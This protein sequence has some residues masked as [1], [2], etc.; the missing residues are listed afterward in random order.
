M[1]QAMFLKHLEKAE[2]HVVEATQDVTRQREIID[3]LARGG[4]STVAALGLLGEFERAMADRVAACECLRR[5]QG[6]A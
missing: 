3:V 1:D 6:R 5:E 4:C 2:R